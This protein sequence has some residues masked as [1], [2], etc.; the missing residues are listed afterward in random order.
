MATKTE[1]QM[2]GKQ[3]CAGIPSQRITI[4]RSAAR[5]SF[6]KGTPAGYT[7]LEEY[8]H[9]KSAPHLFIAKGQATRAEIDLS[10][11]TTGFTNSPKF[12]ISNVTGGTAAQGGAG[13]KLVRFTASK[14][15]GRGGFLFT[16]TDADGSK[17]TQQFAI[18]VTG[19]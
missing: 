16:I 1:C 12:T 7:A 5:A 6:S 8:L 13:G 15:E 4:P 19:S 11:Y 14:T 9:F 18:C 10:H 3:P 2:Y 17:W